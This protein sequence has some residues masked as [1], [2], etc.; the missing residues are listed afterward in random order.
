V[1]DQSRKREL[2]GATGLSRLPAGFA[3]LGFALALRLRAGSR[4]RVL[5]PSQTS[6]RQDSNSKPAPH[7]QVVTTK[8]SPGDSQSS[9][10][11]DSDLQR[12]INAWRDLPTDL[13]A[14][15]ISIVGPNS[16][17]H[18]QLFGRNISEA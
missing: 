4:T 8:D 11:F 7:N 15:I 14:A 1:S 17:S 6:G 16:L 18:R 10:I 9:K 12:V 13:K 2:V 3:N 5:I